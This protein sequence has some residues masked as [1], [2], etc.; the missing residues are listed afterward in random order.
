[1][2][3]TLTEMWLFITWVATVGYVFHLKGQVE[4]EKRAIAFIL[5]G[6]MTKQIDIQRDEDGDVEIIKGEKYVGN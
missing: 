2:E 5:H 3:I 4:H 1:M 6:L